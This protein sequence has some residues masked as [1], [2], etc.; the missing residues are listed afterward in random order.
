ML[1][2]QLKVDLHNKSASTNVAQSASAH[3]CRLKLTFS[4]R[5]L[6]LDATVQYT[7]VY[8][9][10]VIESINL[11]PEFPG[12]APETIWKSLLF[13]RGVLYSVMLSTQKHCLVSSQYFQ[14][15]SRLYIFIV[16]SRQLSNSWPDQCCP[17]LR[18]DHNILVLLER[19]GYSYTLFS[20]L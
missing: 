7:T 8:T 10:D 14:S 12:S 1:I 16:T 4:A 6:W 17:K 9:Y 13:R 3:Q 19:W 15:W 11:I 2:S 5:R 20:Q 18:S